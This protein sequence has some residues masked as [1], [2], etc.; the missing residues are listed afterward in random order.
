MTIIPIASF[1]IIFIIYFLLRLIR[2]RA[3]NTDNYSKEF[4]RIPLWWLTVSIF[5]VFVSLLRFIAIVIADYE[6]DY[7]TIF[8]LNFAGIPII[9][10]TLLIGIIGKER[11]AKK[12]NNTL[13]KKYS[14]YL[15]YLPFIIIALRIIISLFYP[16]RPFAGA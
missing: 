7:G 10:L 15:I 11:L 2:S 1:S 5:L 8:G 16:H 6:G 4:H 14:K 12:T 13:L 9:L 3:K